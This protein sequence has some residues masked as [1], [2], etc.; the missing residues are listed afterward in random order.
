MKN[1]FI[2]KFFD[3]S[4]SEWQTDNVKE[5]NEFIDD[6]RIDYE[7]FYG[8]SENFIKLTPINGKYEDPRLVDIKKDEDDPN[9]PNT[10]KGKRKII[11]KRYDLIPG[12]FEGLERIA[13][14]ADYGAEKYGVDNWKGLDISGEKAPINHAIRHCAKATIYPFGSRERSWQLAKA[15]WNILAQ[16]WFESRVKNGN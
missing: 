8:S 9:N 11:G 15:G 7:V 2:V 5:L 4:K 10:P 6:R 13:E 1:M 12:L 16:L 3:E 14:V